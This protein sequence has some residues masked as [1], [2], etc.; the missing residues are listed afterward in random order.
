MN[1]PLNH[2]FT[3]RFQ[4]RRSGRTPTSRE[5]RGHVLILRIVCKSWVAVV[6][7]ERARGSDEKVEIEKPQRWF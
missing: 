2:V 6:A 5:M 4:Q 1:T 3:V 7:D